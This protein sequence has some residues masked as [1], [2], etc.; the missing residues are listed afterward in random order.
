M[1]EITM[2]TIGLL[3]KNLAITGVSCRK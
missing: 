2:A 3:I 1:M